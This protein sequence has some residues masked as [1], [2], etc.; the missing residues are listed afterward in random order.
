MRKKQTLINV[1]MVDVLT[2]RN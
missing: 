2:H 1:E